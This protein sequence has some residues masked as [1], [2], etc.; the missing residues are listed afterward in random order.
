LRQQ[1]GPENTTSTASLPL[2][3]EPSLNEIPSTVLAC[4]LSE[5]KLIAERVV[6]VPALYERVCRQLR[7]F[8]TFVDVDETPSHVLLENV[9]GVFLVAAITYANSPAADKVWTRARAEAGL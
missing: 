5:L 4:D 6:D 3:G 2:N 1:C 7:A 9:D 8:D